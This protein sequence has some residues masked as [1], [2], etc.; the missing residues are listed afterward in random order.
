ML[1]DLSDDCLAFLRRVGDA[2]AMDPVCF[3]SHVEE[4]LDYLKREYE[5]GQM[6]QRKAGTYS[7]YVTK[8][9]AERSPHSGE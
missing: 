4:F 5:R 6:W 7:L 1:A 3:G 8:R 2:R 9:L